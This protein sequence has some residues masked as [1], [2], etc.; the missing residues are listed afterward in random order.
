MSKPQRIFAGQSVRAL[1][2][3]HGMKQAEM[4]SA[5]SISVSY[6]SQIE[7]DDRPLTAPILATLTR[8]FGMA[9]EEI[10]GESSDARAEALLQAASDPIFAEPLDMAL[11]TRAV[12]QQ[13]QHGVAEIAGDVGGLHGASLVA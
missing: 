9:R 1:R 11:A 4:A 10:G 13:P 3:R 7:N 5:L 2:E 8:R 12:R 6:L